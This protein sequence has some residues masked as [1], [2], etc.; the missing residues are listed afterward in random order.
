MEEGWW[1][2]EEGWWKR[3]KGWWKRE[4]GRWKKLDGRVNKAAV[5]IDTAAYVEMK[6]VTCLKLDGEGFAIVGDKLAVGVLEVE[7][8][9][10][11]LGDEDHIE[12]AILQHAIELTITLAKGNCA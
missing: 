2:R 4:K 10:T 3:E 5:P 7:G 11:V 9:G 12:L 6:K 1:K 8:L